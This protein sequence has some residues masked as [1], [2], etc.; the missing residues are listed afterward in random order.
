[1]KPM[2]HYRINGSQLPKVIFMEKVTVAPPHVHIRRQTDEF[3]LYYVLAGEM[4]ISEGNRHFVLKPNDFLIL[5]PH[6]EHYGTKATTCTYFYIHFLHNQMEECTESIDTLKNELIANRLTALKTH[7]CHPVADTSST[8]MVPKTFHS[9]PTSAL[10]NILHK[11]REAHHNRLEYYQLITSA[12]LLELLVTMSR[13]FTAS[14]LFSEHS[15]PKTRS[16]RMIHD[17]LSH[18]QTNYASDISGAT[19]E[20]RYNCNFDYLNRMFKQATGTTILVHLNEL[21]ISKAKQMLYDGSGSISE[22]SEKCGF[23]DVYYFSKVFKK[24]T[25]LTPGVYAKNRSW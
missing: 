11:L 8:I 9:K 2:L 23:K 20:E 10:V 12:I 17:L 19:I 1:M 14:F 25:G 7:E 3:I 21:R 24:Y 5:D 6:Q 15:I 13:E 16:T 4:H 18:F 22:V